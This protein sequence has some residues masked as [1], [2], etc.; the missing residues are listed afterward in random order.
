M[1]LCAE[2]QDWA[3][4]LVKRPASPMQALGAIRTFRRCL[5]HPLAVRSTVC[6][7]AGELVL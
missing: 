1:Y 5:Y 6:P 2:K 4:Q 3:L 7:R